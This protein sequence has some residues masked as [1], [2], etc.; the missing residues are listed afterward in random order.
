MKTRGLYN[1][2]RCGIPPVPSPVS[3][4]ASFGREPWITPDRHFGVY[5]SVDLK[6][7]CKTV[8]AHIPLICPF[9]AVQDNA[10]LVMLQL[11]DYKPDFPYDVLITKSKTPTRVTRT[12]MLIRLQSTLH[13]YITC[14][15]VWHG[16][17]LLPVAVYE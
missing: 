5:L 12:M 1:G 2:S 8:G 11:S 17:G 10:R 16:K 4:V 15:V 13:L 9:L 6:V 3:I 7:I 14:L